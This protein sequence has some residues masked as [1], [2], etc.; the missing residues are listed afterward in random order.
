MFKTRN[1]SQQTRLS[2]LGSLVTEREMRSNGSLRHTC[3]LNQESAAPVALNHSSSLWLSGEQRNSCL[4]QVMYCISQVRQQITEALTSLSRCQN[5]Q[6]TFSTDSGNFLIVGQTVAQAK[7]RRGFQRNV[8][9]PSTFGN[10]M[11]EFSAY[12]SDK[13]PNI[14]LE[15]QFHKNDKISV[16]LLFIV[17]IL[18]SCKKSFSAGRIISK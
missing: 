6:S 2:H 10:L 18:L 11:S 12:I 1:Y 4:V 17:G 9:V 8:V 7:N 5:N 16:E 3:A 14:Y 13:L 15:G